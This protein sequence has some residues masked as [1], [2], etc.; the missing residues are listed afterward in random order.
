MHPLI[1]DVE[2]MNEQ[3]LHIRIGELNGKLSG[4]YRMGNPA[5]IQQVQM[6]LDTYR[7]KLQELEI[8]KRNKGN[9]KD[10]SDKINIG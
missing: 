5:L 4:A 8:A 2:N 3:E 9:N 10:H 1:T 7:T 6:A